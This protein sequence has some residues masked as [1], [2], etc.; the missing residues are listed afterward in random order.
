[1]AKKKDNDDW[2]KLNNITKYVTGKVEPVKV[3]KVFWQ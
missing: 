1:M 2:R 3:K